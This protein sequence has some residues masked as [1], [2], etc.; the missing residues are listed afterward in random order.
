MDGI[1][2][3]KKARRTR[4]T[5]TNKQA[6][7]CVKYRKPTVIVRSTCEPG[8]S[9]PIEK[10]RYD[11]ALTLYC[12]WWLTTTIQ[13]LTTHSAHLKK[14]SR[15]TKCEIRNMHFKDVEE[16]KRPPVWPSE[17]YLKVHRK[18]NYILQPQPCI[19]K[20]NTLHDS[21]GCVCVCVCACALQMP[22]PIKGRHRLPEEAQNL[23]RR[24]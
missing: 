7:S 15:V 16:I 6:F 21:Q 10:L 18:G 5:L 20:P 9:Y 1:N 11:N 13:H 12:S 17:A 24:Q 4:W 19:P 14:S 22:E 2:Y 8:P 23:P 3:S